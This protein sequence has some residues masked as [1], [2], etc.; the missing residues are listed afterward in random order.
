MLTCEE[1]SCGDA[2]SSHFPFATRGP[3]QQKETPQGL[4]SV[5]S[6]KFETELSGTCGGFRGG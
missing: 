1:M 2:D 3:M 6:G 5:K 4:Y